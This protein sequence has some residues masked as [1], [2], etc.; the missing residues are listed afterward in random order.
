MAGYAGYSKSNNAI[1][2]EHEGKYPATV[3][4][5]RLHVSVEAIR[6]IL[7]PCE[8]HH[9]SKWFNETDYYDIQ[10][11]APETL[12]ALQ[13]YT[14]S[15]MQALTYHAD[16]EW[17]EWTGSRHHPR[18]HPRHAHDCLV[19]EKGCYYTFHLPDQDLRKKIGSTGT[20]VHRLSAVTLPGFQSIPAKVRIAQRTTTTLT[21]LTTLAHDPALAVRRAVAQNPRTP[22]AILTTMSAAPDL[23]VALANNPHLPVSLCTILAQKLTTEGSPSRELFTALLHNPACPP[24]LVEALRSQFPQ[25]IPQRRTAKAPNLALAQDPTTDPA[26]L[27]TYAKSGNATIRLAV[28][29]NPSTPLPTLQHLAHDRFSQDGGATFPIREA[30]QHHPAMRN[31]P[32]A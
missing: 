30:V 5:K 4:A 27:A 11:L 21:M 25:W 24:D 3:C 12:Q 13:A 9:T 8:W 22:L 31:P 14:P 19:T 16:V 20:V 7:T 1:D 28:A 29:E 15:Q 18:A 23:H 2:A 26:L 6:A 17:I 32:H 10:D